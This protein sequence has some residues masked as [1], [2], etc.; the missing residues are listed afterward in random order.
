MAMLIIE[1]RNTSVLCI[2]KMVKPTEDLTGTDVILLLKP[3]DSWHK[4]IREAIKNG[5]NYLVL[6]IYLGHVTG[7]HK[8]KTSIWGE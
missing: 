4:S 1:K 8:S 6:D 3:A 5:K 2:I 7:G